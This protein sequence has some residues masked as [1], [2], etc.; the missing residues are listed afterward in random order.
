VIEDVISEIL[1]TC[2]EED[3]IKMINVE[4]LSRLDDEDVKQTWPAKKG[5][6]KEF[7]LGY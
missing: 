3:N 6:K 7:C 1:F 4:S 2:E 5:E